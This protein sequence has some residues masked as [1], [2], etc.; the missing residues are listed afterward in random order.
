MDSLDRYAGPEEFAQMLQVT[1]NQINV[2]RHRK[3]LPEPCGELSGVP[4]WLRSDIVK[5]A[6]LTGRE[7]VEAP[8]PYQA[9]WDAKRSI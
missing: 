6:I 4:I 1:R 7:T 9:T 8:S 5:W 3:Q 2:W